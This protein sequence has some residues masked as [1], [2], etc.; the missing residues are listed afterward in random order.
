MNEALDIWSHKNKI[1]RTTFLKGKLLESMGK[2]QV[3]PIAI[4]V[5]GRLREEITKGDRDVESLTMEGFHGIVA[6]W[7][8]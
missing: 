3:S 2:T 5:A 4:R 8:R 1:G 7:A 6:F